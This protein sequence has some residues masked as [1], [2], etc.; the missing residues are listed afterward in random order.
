M[1]EVL[2]MK[3]QTWLEYFQNKVY[4]SAFIFR[5]KLRFAEID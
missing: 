5:Y 1:N 2:E 4:I 3:V